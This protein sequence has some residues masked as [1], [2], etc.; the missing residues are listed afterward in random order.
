MRSFGVGEGYHEGRGS[1]VFRLF[2]K[3]PRE[4]VSWIRRWRDCSRAL[5][6]SWEG[7]VILAGGLL[8]LLC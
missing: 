3:E 6:V 7:V 2:I 1:W 4:W 5:R 8:L